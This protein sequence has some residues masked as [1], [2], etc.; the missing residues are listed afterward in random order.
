M[1]PETD[2]NQLTMAID[3]K[4]NRIRIHKSTLR[5]LGSPPF[6][7]LLLSPKH[8]AIAILKSEKQVPRGQEII[9]SFD[10]PDSS[11]TFLI[12]SKD[13]ISLIR[14]EFPGLEKDG[15]YRLSGRSVPEEGGVWF[16]LDSLV[17]T[18]E[19]HV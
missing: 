16:P 10:R 15:L 9:V 14:T 19:K 1:M 6:I 7:K 8:R 12:Y 17:W 13:L 2:R 5:L 4:K 11:G 18:E 3:L